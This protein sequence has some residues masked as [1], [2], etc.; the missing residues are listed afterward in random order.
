VSWSAGVA[1]VSWD[2]L[3]S[4]AAGQQI[5]VPGHGLAPPADHLPLAGSG[6]ASPEG[7]PVEIAP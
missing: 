7:R 4:A 5:P 1:H 2:D 6:R 3:A